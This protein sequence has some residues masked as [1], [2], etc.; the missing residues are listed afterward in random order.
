M[1][2]NKAGFGIIAVVIGVVIL[3]GIIFL[4]PR[5]NPLNDAFNDVRPLGVICPKSASHTSSIENVND[6]NDEN[7]YADCSWSGSGLTTQTAVASIAHTG[8]AFTA[9]TTISNGPGE[10]YRFEKTIGKRKYVL[11]IED[12]D[13]SSIEY[14]KDGYPLNVRISTQ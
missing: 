6:S 11:K 2:K 3:C 10:M 8:W 5:S 9:S 14:R 12:S 13:G 7:T 4:I 1:M